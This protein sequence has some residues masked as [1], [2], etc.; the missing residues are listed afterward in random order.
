MCVWGGRHRTDSVSEFARVTGPDADGCNRV[1]L[2]FPTNARDE[3][4]P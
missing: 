2:F 4:S 3:S 1:G